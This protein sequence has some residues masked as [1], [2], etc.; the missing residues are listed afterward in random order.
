MI[1][2]VNNLDMLEEV[3]PKYKSELLRGRSHLVEES[4]RSGAG[5]FFFTQFFHIL[6]QSSIC[7]LQ[8]STSKLILIFSVSN[9]PC[10]FS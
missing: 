4:E 6:L 7:N 5:S 10:L 3:C 9:Y 8:P 2:N 1:F